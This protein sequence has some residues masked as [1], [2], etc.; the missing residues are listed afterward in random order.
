MKG[1]RCAQLSCARNGEEEEY[2]LGLGEGGSVLGF[3][4]FSYARVSLVCNVFE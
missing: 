3:Q 2:G 4:A 1:R